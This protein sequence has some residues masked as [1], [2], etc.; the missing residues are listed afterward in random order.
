[1]NERKNPLEEALDGID[2]KLIEESTLRLY[3]KTDNV[4]K[5]EFITVERE[6]KKSK[7]GVFWGITGA[8]AAAAALITVG[9]IATN[10]NG[11]VNGIEITLPP[12][13]PGAVSTSE[14]WEPSVVTTVVLTENPEW[15]DEPGN[16]RASWLGEDKSGNVYAFDSA[17]K[18]ILAYSGNGVITALEDFDY[19]VDITTE[20]G[21]LNQDFSGVVDDGL[22]F[23]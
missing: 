1:M 18:K 12:D 20:Y 22:Y 15:I 8:A 17:L 7:K 9:G 6:G 14:P 3:G 4:Q 19:F 21:F 13:N 5:A 10:Y 2:E 16:F 23:A 11:I